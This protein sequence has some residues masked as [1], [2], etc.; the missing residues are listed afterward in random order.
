MSTETE[1]VSYNICTCHSTRHSICA[2]VSA[3]QTKVV[4][5]AEA[6]VLQIFQPEGR[7]NDGQHGDLLGTAEYVPHS[8]DEVFAF[9]RTESRLMEMQTKEYLRRSAAT[10]KKGSSDGLNFD[11]ADLLTPATIEAIWR[12]NEFDDKASLSHDQLKSL[13]SELIELVEGPATEAEGNI[14]DDEVR[15]AMKILDANKNETVELEE[16]LSW[17][18]SNPSLRTFRE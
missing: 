1:C 3:V 16:L 11:S 6:P 14:S 12:R 5:S 10:T 18:E 8:K 2:E 9:A 15:V 17:V 13:L 7:S 4:I